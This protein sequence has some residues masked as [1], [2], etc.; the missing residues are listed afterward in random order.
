MST[1]KG[2]KGWSYVSAPTAIDAYHIVSAG[3]TG[4][5]PRVDITSVATGIWKVVFTWDQ[6]TAAD[7]PAAYQAVGTGCTGPTPDIVQITPA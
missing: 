7:P 6:V 2:V 5:T 3:C 4:P 1:F